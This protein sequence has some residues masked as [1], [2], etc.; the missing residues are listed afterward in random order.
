MSLKNPVTPPGIDPGTVGL[1]AQCLNQYATPGPVLSEVHSLKTLCMYIKIME[2][3]V[4]ST[5]TLISSVSLYPSP[6]TSK[7]SC[8]PCTLKPHIFTKVCVQ[9]CHSYQLC[10]T[11]PLTNNQQA[12]L[13]TL[14]IEATHLH[15]RHPTTGQTVWWRNRCTMLQ[16][17]KHVRLI[18]TVALCITA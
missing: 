18:N 14:Y 1:V 2:K 4:Y 11:L 6:T 5:A 8:L 10:V 3:H 13:S 16:Q 17:M 7:Q 12:I 9:H 15:K